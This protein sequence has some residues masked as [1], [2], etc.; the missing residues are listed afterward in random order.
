METFRGLLDAGFV[1]Y[2]GRVVVKIGVGK[3]QGTLFA[4]LAVQDHPSECCG[5]RLARRL[6]GQPIAFFRADG[7]LKGKA[8]EPNTTL[9]G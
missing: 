1:I 9:S 6:N 4:D 7:S 2:A 5:K 3:L 8:S